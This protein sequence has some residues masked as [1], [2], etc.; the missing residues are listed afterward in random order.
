[1][2]VHPRLDIG[3]QIDDLAHDR[4]GY[5]SLVAQPAIEIGRGNFEVAAQVDLA[6]ERLGG[7]AQRLSLE[8]AGHTRSLQPVKRSYAA[9]PRFSGRRPM[10]SWLSQ[11]EKCT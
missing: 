6:A 11:E 9:A 10:T 1:M 7:L 8:R 5:R 4:A 2:I 3:E